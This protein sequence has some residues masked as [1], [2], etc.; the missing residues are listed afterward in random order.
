M[1]VGQRRVCTTVSIVDDGEVENTE[2]FAMRMFYTAV[3]NPK[4]IPYN[5]EATVFIYDDDCTYVYAS[6][7]LP[8]LSFTN[9]YT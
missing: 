3:E 7:S 1:M 2:T 6:A 9:L 5:R 4:I 8:Q